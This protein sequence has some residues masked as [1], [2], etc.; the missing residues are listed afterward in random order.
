M[1]MKNYYI[2][3]IKGTED[4]GTFTSYL[5]Y[6]Q[7]L[8]EYQEYLALNTTQDL[9]IDLSKIVKI[10]PLVIPNLIEIGLKHKSEF[11]G[12]S[13]FLFIPW[14]IILV[15]YLRDIG[16]LSYVRKYQIFNLF[17]EYLGGITQ[18]RKLG[19][20]CFTYLVELGTSKEYI[21]NNYFTEISEILEQHLQQ[22]KANDVIKFMVELCHNGANHSNSPCFFT[23]QINKYGYFLFSIADS[24]IGLF[25]TFRNKIQKNEKEL[26]FFQKVHFDIENKAKYGNL[27]SIFEAIFYRYQTE[28]YGIHS[29]F[30]S[31][32]SQ[33]G[34]KIRFHTH[35]TQIIFTNKVYYNHFFGAE[36]IEQIKLAIRSFYRNCKKNIKQ[37]DFSY[38]GVHVE[39]EIPF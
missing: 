15:E 34:A 5:F 26:K 17:E 9:L 21:R 30:N 28:T 35:D 25:E 13:I 20:N 29:V 37:T 8:P 2:I 27:A 19:E 39:I 33:E 22:E 36:S 7:F 24:G 14:N 11:D 32:L 4:S 1:A 12:N 3:Q 38:D 16:F 10:N 6:N 31:V 18:E 23:V